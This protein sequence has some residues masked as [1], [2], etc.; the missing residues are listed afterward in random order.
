MKVV[1]SVKAPICESSSKVLIS[2]DFLQEVPTAVFLTLKT[3][4]QGI[5][6][7]V[8]HTQEVITHGGLTVFLYQSLGIVY[9]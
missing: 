4:F 3:N 9:F 6:D 5:L 8:G 1:N 2:G 7:T